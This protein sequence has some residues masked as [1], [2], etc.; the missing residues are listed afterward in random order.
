MIR[1]TDS[2]GI[3]T[4]SDRPAPSPRSEPAAPTP[5]GAAAPLREVPP[6]AGASL[7]AFLARAAGYA[8]RRLLR[9]L[10]AA[11]AAWWR[12]LARR[13]IRSA[14]HP[15]SICLGSGAAPIAGWVNV[16][17]DRRAPVRLDLRFPLPMADASAGLVYS[18]HVIEHLTLEDGLALLRECRRVLREDGVLRI[19]T[20]D[21]DSLVRSYLGDWRAQDWV[22]WV[23]H[24]W[25]DS[26]ALML[27]VAFR[28]W[29]HQHLYDHDE[30]TLRLAAAGFGETRRCAIGESATPG[31]AG[32][33]TRADSLLIVEAWGDASRRRP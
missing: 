16:D 4:V 20:P 13:K 21:L 5:T 26:R 22:N 29:G 12:A 32:L 14:P 15:L 19:A 3:S 27:N 33:E 17:M 8:S 2:S 6:A 1:S 28:N 24:E 9:A 11:R 31:L 30:L 10:A 7:P 25:I 23:G 18:E